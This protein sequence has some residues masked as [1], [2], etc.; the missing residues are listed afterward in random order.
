MRHVREPEQIDTWKEA[1]TV[2]NNTTEVLATPAAAA[3]MGAGSAW[4]IVSGPR[5]NHALAVNPVP[6]AVRPEAPCAMFGQVP[7]LATPVSTRKQTTNVLKTRISA[8][9]YGAMGPHPEREP[10]PA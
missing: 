1:P 9:G 4:A 8:G 3:L 5:V 10:E 6:S 7:A 2:N